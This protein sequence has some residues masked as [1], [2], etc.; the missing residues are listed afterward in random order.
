MT[1]IKKFMW[2]I[3]AALLVI[4]YIASCDVALIPSDET[5]NFVN[6]AISD[7]GDGTF[8]INFQ[9]GKNTETIEYAVRYA[10]N[11]KTDS[12]A[13]MSGEL[14]N[15]I[16]IEPEEDGTASVSFDFSEP[17]DFGPYTV[18]AHAISE[19]GE[20]SD[21]A[22][23]QVCALTTG[24][25]LEYVSRATYAL[26]A[27][28]HGDGF[29]YSA[30]RQSKNNFYNTVS[31]YGY[32]KSLQGVRDYINDILETESPTDLTP[33]IDDGQTWYNS[34]FYSNYYEDEQ[35]ISQLESQIICFATS[36]GTKITGVYAFEIPL[37]ETD[38]AAPKAGNL[39][40][41]PDFSEPRIYN[42]EIEGETEIQ[43]N[44][45]AYFPVNVHV[46][47][48]CE[49]YSCL[50]Y[51]SES[52]WWSYIEQFRD[53]YTPTLTLEE[54][55]KWYMTS[56]IFSELRRWDSTYEVLLYDKQYSDKNVY[57]KFYYSESIIV[58]C[59]V[60]WN[61]E[62]TLQLIPL[63]IP[64]EYIDKYVPEGY[65][66]YSDY[67]DSFNNLSMA[68]MPGLDKI[69]AVSETLQTKFLLEGK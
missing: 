10:V 33:A 21:L 14:D 56:G 57:Y 45:A 2:R 66:D 19:S 59:T 36:D 53:I 50:P 54:A 7:V 51:Y 20:T 18:Y 13:F 30:Y 65:T 68:D 64:Q 29:I 58:A 3:L 40:I 38:P 16:K 35:Y 39:D 69:P 67:M 32:E 28:Y 22:K 63:E 27:S 42:S 12:V 17:L 11:M 9:C 49:F 4:P 60:N 26:K 47:N 31:E 24:A 55:T 8:T 6:L 15:I 25:T 37:Q 44:E 61:N 34:F 1:M 5:D 48:N 43:Y 23:Q 52:I 46:G 41:Q 62:V